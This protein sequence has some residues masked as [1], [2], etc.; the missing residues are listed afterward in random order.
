MN[1]SRFISW[2]REV[3]D[4][5]ELAGVLASTSICFDLSVFEIFVPL[6]FGGKVILV[7]NALQ[8]ARV[9]DTEVR[10]VNT[11][12]TVMAELVRAAE[13]PP[14][15]TTVSLAGE[16]LTRE[17]ADE[18]YK[19]PNIKRL[20]NLYG[21]SEDT[22]YSTLSPVVRSSAAAPPIGGPITNTQ[23][24]LAGPFSELVP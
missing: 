16:L 22:T 8:R 17:L 2:A 24:W 3:F 4:D 20:L 14:F 12:P 11:V 10:L 9:S 6:T 23:L 15:A 7:D 5:S 19:V 21:P 1:V 13:V 18:I